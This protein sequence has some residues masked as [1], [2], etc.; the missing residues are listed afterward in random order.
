MEKVETHIAD[1]D[2]PQ[3]KDTSHISLRN[4]VYL[5]LFNLKQPKESFS[6]VVQRLIDNYKEQQKKP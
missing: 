1:R 4:D 5:A 6:K 2:Q 3:N